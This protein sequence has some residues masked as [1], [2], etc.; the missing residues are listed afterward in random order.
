LGN[1]TASYPSWE[2][3]LLA[4][5]RAVQPD[6]RITRYNGFWKSLKRRRIPLPNGHY[7]EEGMQS[8]EGGLRFFG[9]MHF[10]LDQLEC[11][12]EILMAEQ[13]AI[14]MVSQAQS[15]TLIPPLIQ[16]GWAVCN[17]APPEEILETVCPKSGVV[18]G[19]YGEFDDPDVSVGAIGKKEVVERIRRTWDGVSS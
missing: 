18:V 6:N 14:A 4:G 8:S 16:Q 5:H 2:L 12:H 19:V 15:A 11:V 3:W 17:T 9:A 7:L 1:L 10:G 13:A